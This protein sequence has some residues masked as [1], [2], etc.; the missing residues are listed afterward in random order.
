MPVT[1]ELVRGTPVG[2]LVE[3]GR[4]ARMVPDMREVPRFIASTAFPT[5]PTPRSAR[6]VRSPSPRRSAR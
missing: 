4:T 1:H 3:L 2:A 6:A 5:T